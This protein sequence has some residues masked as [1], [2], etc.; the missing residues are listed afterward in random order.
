MHPIC[1]ENGELLNF[2]VMPGDDDRKPL[3]D[4]HFIEQIFDKFIAD[5][6]IC[7]MP[8]ICL[9]YNLWLTLI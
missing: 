8:P 7:K 4:K 6:G 3:E 9:L 5:K 1:Y 2:I